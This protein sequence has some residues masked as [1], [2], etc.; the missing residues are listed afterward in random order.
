M[1]VQNAAVCVRP[2][3]HHHRPK[4]RAEFPWIVFIMT[5][6]KTQASLTLAVLALFSVMPAAG[7]PHKES[8]YAKTCMDCTTPH[9]RFVPRRV[10]HAGGGINRKMYTNSLEALNLNYDLGF[11]YFEIDLLHTADGHLVC[12]HD[13]EISARE[14]LGQAV[15]QPLTLAAFKQRIKTHGGLTPCTQE[16]LTMWLEKHPDA[17]VVTD[18]KDDNLGSLAQLMT[19]SPAAKWQI[20]PQV[21]QPDNLEKVAAMG[22]E[23]IIWTLYRYTGSHDEIIR[24]VKRFTPHSA[25][26]AVT[27]P[28][29]KAQSDL[30]GRLKQL[31]IPTYVHTINDPRKAMMF[32]QKYSVTEIYTATLAPSQPGQ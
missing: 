6:K 8:D 14:L 10:A 3:Y 1:F 32:R 18:I 12:L 24:H 2:L 30:P 27:M 26:L 16:T 29:Y 31:G 5:L 11:R 4:Y 22:F 25:G 23:Q 19:M 20:I 15:D 9:N 13:W 21:Y 28:A 7:T 17:Y